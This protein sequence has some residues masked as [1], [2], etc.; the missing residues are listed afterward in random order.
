MD[1]AAVLVAGTKALGSGLGAF[2]A[3]VFNPPKSI[4]DLA[5]RSAFAFLCGM[6]FG[7]PAREQYLHWPERWEYWLA[8]SALVALVSWAVYGAAIRLIGAYKGPK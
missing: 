7:D 8:S 6:I 3:L 4:R 2:L 1:W 5:I